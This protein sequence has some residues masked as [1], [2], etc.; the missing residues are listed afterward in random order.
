MAS[1]IKVLDMTSGLHLECIKVCPKAGEKET[2]NPY[3]LYITYKAPTRSGYGY[4]T[5]KKLV[6][7]YGDMI[8]ILCMIKDIYLEGIDTYPVNVAIDWCNKYYNRRVG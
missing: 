7:K 6:A 8:S 5:H 2:V 4:S 3:L 1:K